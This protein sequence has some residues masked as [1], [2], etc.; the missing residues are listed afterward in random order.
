MDLYDVMRT[1][2]AAREFT[3]EPL[4]D[5]T[6]YRI[7]DNARLRPEAATVRRPAGVEHLA[8][9]TRR[10]DMTATSARWWRRKSRGCRNCWKF[11]IS[12]PSLGC[13]LSAGRRDK[14]PSCAARPLTKSPLGSDSTG[15][16]T[17]LL[18]NLGAPRTAAKRAVAARDSPDAKEW[19]KA[20]S[21]LAHDTC[22]PKYRGH[23]RTGRNHD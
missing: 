9:P 3:G 16:R 7:L 22:K 23:N 19:L 21:F 14:S 1:T 13:W 15:R 2:F 20:G 5:S 8:G 17:H 18:T 12:V 11:P 6:L 10:K 4:P